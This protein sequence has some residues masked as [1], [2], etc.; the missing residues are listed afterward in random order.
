M[1]EKIPVAV[2]GATGAVGQRFVQLLATHPWFSVAAVTGSERSAGKRYGEAVRWLLPGPPPEA[3]AKLTVLPTTPEVVE[4][5][6]AFSALDAAAAEEV[7][8][9]FRAAGKTVVSNAKSHR[10]DPDVPLVVPEINGDH[11]ALVQ[12]QRPRYGG[13]IVTNPNCT[14]IGLCLAL[15]PLRLRFGLRRVLV[16]SLQ[17]LS[18]AGYPGVASLDILDNV[19]PEIAGEEEKV[20]NEPRK[21]FGRLTDGTVE[22]S[23]LSISAQCNRVAS[24]DGHLLSVSVELGSRATLEDVRRAYMEYTSPLADLALPSAPARPVLFTEE[25]A[26]P[27][28][29]LDRD[30]AGGM[31]VTVGRLKRC[32]VLE[33]RFVALVHN[34]I[35]GAAGGTILIAELMRAR[36]LV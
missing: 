8:A 24:R 23:S 34:T 11:L 1:V 33:Y 14:T 30:A 12:T 2:L 5:S 22:P 10:W 15:E 6:L 32:A 9:A 13:A 3:I 36:G 29:L 17:A 19:L 20:E 28:P 35:R 7:E 25:F 4:P 26:R 18:G 31:A 27:Q 21:I 16:T